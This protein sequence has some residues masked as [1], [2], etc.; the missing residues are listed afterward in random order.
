[1]GYRELTSYALRLYRELLNFIYSD[2]RK[3]ASRSKGYCSFIYTA[4]YIIIIIIIIIIDNDFYIL[5]QMSN[6][7]YHG[8]YDSKMNLSTFYRCCCISSVFFF[9]ELK[10][11]KFPF[12]PKFI[13]TYLGIMGD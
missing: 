4:H 7:T 9:I 1:M 13:I 2:L 11:N 6:H 5:N 8:H 10:T 3:L 12:H